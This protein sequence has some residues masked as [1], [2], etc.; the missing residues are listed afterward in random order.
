MTKKNEIYHLKIQAYDVKI[1][2]S[3]HHNIL[4]K[5]LKYFSLNVKGPIFL[6]LKKKK[7]VLLK[8]PHG[9]K[10]AREMF[11]FNTYR[12]LYIISFQKTNQI[13]FFF[14]VLKKYII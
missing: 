3:F 13:T 12:Y 5:L 1:L 4:L 8:S 7:I 6:P 10:K 2:H 14:K 11:A 9:H